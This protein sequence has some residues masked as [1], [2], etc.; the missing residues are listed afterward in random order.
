MKIK[1]YDEEDKRTVT[2]PDVKTVWEVG[3]TKKVILR[4]NGKEEIHHF[5]MLEISD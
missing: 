4:R 3:T 2:I 5:K 1:V